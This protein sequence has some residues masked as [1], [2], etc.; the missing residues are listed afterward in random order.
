MLIALLVHYIGLKFQ[1]T[2][3][4]NMSL[5]FITSLITGSYISQAQ[6]LHCVTIIYHKQSIALLDNV[7]QV[8]HFSNKVTGFNSITIQLHANCLVGPTSFAV[9]IGFS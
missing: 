2:C 4:Q 7:L 3:F 1:Y 5:S 6:Q 9:Q 8:L